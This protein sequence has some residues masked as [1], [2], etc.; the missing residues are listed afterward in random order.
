MDG[1]AGFPK[2]DFE[3]VT[4]N[5]LR[6]WKVENV[7]AVL[8]KLQAT[9]GEIRSQKLV[10][11]GIQ[12][13]T[14]DQIAGGGATHF[15]KP[16]WEQVQESS[17]STYAIAEIYRK[18]RHVIV[19][20]AQVMRLD[21]VDEVDTPVVLCL[22]KWRTR[23]WTFQEIKLATDAIFVAGKGFVNFWDL[24]S[25]LKT[26]AIPEALARRPGQ[27][28]MLRSTFTCM[29]KT[30]NTTR[31][32]RDVA[33]ACATRIAG[34]RLDLARAL[35]PTLSLE[36]STS[37]TLDDGMK[38]IY[39][40]NKID[41]TL[42]PLMHGPPRAAYPGWAPATFSGVANAPVCDTF[43]YGTW[44]PGGMA[45]RWLTARV[46]GLFQIPKFSFGYPR[47]ES[48]DL[49]LQEAHENR[50]TGIESRLWI[51]SISNE[52]IEQTP[53]VISLLENAVKNGT[54][55]MLYKAPDS[56]SLSLVAL[57]VERFAMA[58]DDEAWVYTTLGL[59]I[60]RENATPP[61]PPAEET[62]WLLLHEN[63]TTEIGKPMSEQNYLLERR[64]LN[65]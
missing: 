45:R 55:Y 11:F 38:V 8:Q 16:T 40:A 4:N 19:L 24:I 42:L 15:V 52:T 1:R 21:S 56:A 22:E 39:E 27:F 62:Q 26:K 35:F 58:T 2:S 50:S 60:P 53:N 10:S 17:W 48:V 31:I 5:E 46:S 59:A 47:S 9:S 13:S 18:A 6:Y 12:L 65:T 51:G 44:T 20:D 34:D 28:M 3:S 23:I 37:Y 14:D 54:A 43:D 41:I 25:V 61:I 32:F 29:A 63:P 64:T 33:Y 7:Q 57:F 36:W 49:S 30:R